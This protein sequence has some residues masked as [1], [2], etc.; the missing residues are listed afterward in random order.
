VEELLSSLAMASSKVEIVLE[1]AE[2][3]EGG[4]ERPEVRIGS[5]G[6]PPR[7]I[8]KVASGGE[9]SRL[10]LAL[11]LATGSPAGSP[12]TLVF[13]EVDT[14]VGGEA[15]RA[16]G[17]CLAELARSN[18]RQVI[19]VTHLPQVAA[20]AEGHLRVARTT[21]SDGSASASVER[22][23]PQARV[24][25]LS[26]MLAGLP[27]SDTAREHAQELLEIASSG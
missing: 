15:A 19:V 16:V 17:R 12:T 13:D 1:P 2:L 24:E 21:G 27:D 23:D 5:G 22:L 25:E 9:L 11:R 8:R 7:P 14:G 26:R 10:A 20:F 4:I 6:H 18:E 3:Y